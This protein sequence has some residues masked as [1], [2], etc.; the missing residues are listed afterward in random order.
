MWKGKD[1]TTKIK[2]KEK[3]NFMKNFNEDYHFTSARYIRMMCEDTIEVAIYYDT[4]RYNIGL[5]EYEE[6][7][8]HNPLK[9]EYAFPT[10]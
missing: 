7:N 2:I 5:A 3:R 1:H 8:K 4:D 6:L 9:T 10:L